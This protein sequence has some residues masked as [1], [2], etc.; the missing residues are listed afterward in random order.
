MIGVLRSVMKQLGCDPTSSWLSWA[1]LFRFALFD[2]FRVIAYLFLLLQYIPAAADFI[3]ISNIA[4][5]FPRLAY[6]V[7]FETNKMTAAGELDQDIRRTIRATFRSMESPPPDTFL[8][9]QNSFLEGWN[10]LPYV[11]GPH[12]DI[13]WFR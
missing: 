6:Q 3:P 13:L 4:A 11:T 5:Y 9:H 7:Y 12:F 8:T 10:N 1:S 2:V